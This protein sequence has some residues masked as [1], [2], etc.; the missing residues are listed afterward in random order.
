M[1]HHHPDEAR[2]KEFGLKQMW[3]SPNAPSATSSRGDLPRADHLQERAAPRPRWTKPIIIGRHAY[4][5]QYRATDIRFP[6]KA[7]CR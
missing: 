1:R 5:D 2:V 7:R 3:R 4:G 6:G